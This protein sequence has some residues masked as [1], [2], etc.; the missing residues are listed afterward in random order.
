MGSPDE[1]EVEVD[2]LDRRSAENLLRSERLQRQ[3]DE[4]L[5][6]GRAHL[7]A[8]DVSLARVRELTAAMG[9]DADVDADADEHDASRSP[10]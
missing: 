2:A 9:A 4:T 7:V 6:R 1:L 3:T 5:V 8:I 10:D